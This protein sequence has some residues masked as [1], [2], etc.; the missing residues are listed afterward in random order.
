MDGVFADFEE[1]DVVGV[2]GF[3]LLEEFEELNAGCFCGLFFG[4]TV[5][6]VVDVFGKRVVGRGSVLDADGPV[7]V[8]VGGGEP[9]FGIEADVEDEEGG[10]FALVLVDELDGF[11]EG[12]G[13]GFS[14]ELDPDGGIFM[15]G[16]PFFEAGE[17]GAVGRADVGGDVFAEGGGVVFVVSRGGAVE[18]G[19]ELGL[20]FAA[21][22]F[23]GVLLRDE[24][25]GEKQEEGEYAAKNHD[26]AGRRYP[27]DCGAGNRDVLWF[28]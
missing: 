24:E 5:E 1:V 27:M 3:E 7:A 19:T 22:V 28:T 18:P 14:M 13:I 16:E 11:G 26:D 9:G 15:G 12:C 25:G 8:G 23:P 6:E 4:A 17:E 21:G 2:F 10:V 20:L